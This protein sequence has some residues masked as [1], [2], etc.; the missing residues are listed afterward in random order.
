MEPE[1]EKAKRIYLPSYQ[2][3]SYTARSTC[4]GSLFTWTLTLLYVP[5]IHYLPITYYPPA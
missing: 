5:I 2:S 4:C 3:S 1:G